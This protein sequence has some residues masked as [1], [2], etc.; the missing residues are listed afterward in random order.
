VGASL[1]ALQ[2]SAGTPPVQAGKQAIVASH[3][4]TARHLSQRRLNAKRLVA[5]LA[6]STGHDPSPR[7]AADLAPCLAPADLF[8]R[9][10][11][12]PARA[13]PLS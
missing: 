5:T 6:V 2:L 12:C 1:L 11:S 4:A 3:H 13:P 7:I 9:A 8:R 10:G